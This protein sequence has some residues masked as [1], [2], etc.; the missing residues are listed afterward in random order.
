MAICFRVETSVQNSYESV[1]ADILVKSETSHGVRQPIRAILAQSLD[2][3]LHLLRCHTGVW[4]KEAP[5][6]KKETD[7]ANE[8]GDDDMC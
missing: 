1:P 7:N 8:K 3:L 5:E 4:C 2:D 6:L